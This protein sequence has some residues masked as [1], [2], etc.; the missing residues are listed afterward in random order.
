MHFTTSEF[1]TNYE[2]SGIIDFTTQGYVSVN[3]KRRKVIKPWNNNLSYV[4]INLA[5]KPLYQSDQGEI[6]FLE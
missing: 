4:H 2:F 6:F 3:N 1:W 5:I